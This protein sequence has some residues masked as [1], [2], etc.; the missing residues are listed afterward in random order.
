MD[1]DP[2]AALRTGARER[3]TTFVDGPLR[4]GLRSGRRIGRVRP[5]PS[6][7]SFG[8]YNSPIGPTKLKQEIAPILNDF[9]ARRH[10]VGEP[11]GLHRLG[12]PCGVAHRLADGVRRV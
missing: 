6:V 12:G 3:R 4:Q 7:K 2:T 10:V 9:H 1:D 8:R 5:S 11:A